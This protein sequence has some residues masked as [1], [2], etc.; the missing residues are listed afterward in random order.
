LGL[1][2]PDSGVYIKF[3]SFQNETW[4]PKAEQNKIKK[5]I[6]G[7]YYDSADIEGGSFYI[8]LK[9]EYYEKLSS[10]DIDVNIQ[11]DII[12]NFLVEILDILK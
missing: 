2:I 6:D 11:K 8:H 3:Q 4:L 7:K 10:D 5:I 12:K 9:D 1:Y